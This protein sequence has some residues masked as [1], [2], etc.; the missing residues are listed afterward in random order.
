MLLFIFTITIFNSFY[1]IK[2]IEQQDAN[3]TMNNITKEQV[4]NLL[5]S[6]M[7]EVVSEVISYLSNESSI[8]EL[9]SR[10]NSFGNTSVTSDSTNANPQSNRLRLC[11]PIIQNYKISEK[12][13]LC[14]I[15]RMWYQG[16]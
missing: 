13:T 6:S 3:N 5:K 7:S 4:E 15:H 14:G 8:E 9:N 11:N 10:L 12:L 16:K 1:F 2:K